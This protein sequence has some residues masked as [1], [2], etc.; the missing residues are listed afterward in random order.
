MRLTLGTNDSPRWDK[1]DRTKL[2]NG[3]RNQGRWVSFP[4]GLIQRKEPGGR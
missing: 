2:E 1:N 4:L 3:N